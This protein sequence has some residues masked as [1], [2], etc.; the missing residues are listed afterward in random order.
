MRPSAAVRP[1][2]G[3]V[4]VELCIHAANVLYLISF[5]AR[6]MLWLRLLTCAGLLL[7][8]LFFSCQPMPL[9]G[10]TVWHVVFLVINGLQIWRLLA[11]RRRLTLTA[12]Q[13]RVGE[14][15]FHD[16]SREELLTLL[17]RVTWEGPAKVLDVENACHQQLTREEGVLRD[18][19]FSRLS[20]SEL[21][22]LLTRRMWCSIVKLRP[23]T[24]RRPGQRDGG[25]GV[26]SGSAAG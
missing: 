8:V 10:P 23:S 18:I 22:N 2:E 1:L 4:L 3:N 19:A 16:L 11:E 5:L 25:A 17:A 15:A 20:R 14:A 21:V 9:Y 24:W 12:K 6:D 7:G 13:E 26:T